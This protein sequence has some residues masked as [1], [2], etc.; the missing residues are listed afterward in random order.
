[1]NNGKRE[2][3]QREEKKEKADRKLKSFETSAKRNED[4]DLGIDN[5]AKTFL[6]LF[7]PLF[8]KARY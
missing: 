4:K 8:F 5:E 3:T 1:M 7:N 6:S 2:Q